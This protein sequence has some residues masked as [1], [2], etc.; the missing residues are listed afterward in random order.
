MTLFNFIGYT[1]AEGRIIMNGE[2]IRMRKD[3]GMTSFKVLAH[4]LFGVTEKTTKSSVK[5]Y[6]LWAEI[7]ASQIQNRSVLPVVLVRGPL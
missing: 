3:A 4:H 5:I 1:V 2:L 6:D 7:K